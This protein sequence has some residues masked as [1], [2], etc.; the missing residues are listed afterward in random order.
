MVGGRVSDT[1]MLARRNDW[2]AADVTTTGS[3]GR[4]GPFGTVWR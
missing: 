4:T 1:T 2:I 3:V